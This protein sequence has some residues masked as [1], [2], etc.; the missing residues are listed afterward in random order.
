MLGIIQPG[1]DSAN[2]MESKLDQTLPEG[3]K[4]GRDQTLAEGWKTNWDLTLPERW[5][6]SS[7]Q[8]A[9]RMENKLGPDSAIMLKA[10]MSAFLCYYNTYLD[11][12]Y[13]V[14]LILLRSKDPLEEKFQ[15]SIFS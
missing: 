7:G 6:S 2:R 12:I 11:G 1:S 9:R 14:Q 10:L 13:L 15:I 3:W 5:K 8:T 4:T